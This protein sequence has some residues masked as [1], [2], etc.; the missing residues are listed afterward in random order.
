MF[1]SHTPVLPC[2]RALLFLLSL[3]PLLL[4][5]PAVVYSQWEPDRRLTFNAT[6]GTSPNNAWCVAAMGDSV[7]VVWFDRR[8]VDCEIYYKR[9]TDGGLTWGQDVQLSNDPDTSQSPSLAVAG[10]K[11]HVVWWDHRDGNREI[12]YKRSTDG[13]TTWGQEIRLTNDFSYSGSP[14]LAASGDSVHVVWQDY[15]D[16][17]LEVYYK[18]STDGGSSWLSE[19]R[20]TDNSSESACPSIAASGPKVHVVWYDYRDG[21]YEIYYKRSTDAG[22]TWGSDFRLSYDPAGSERPALAVSDSMIH[23]VWEDYRDGTNT[24]EIYYKRSTNG[25]TSWESDTRLTYNSDWS[26][27]PSMATSDPAVHIVWHDDRDRGSEIYYKRSTDRGMTWGSDTRLT[28]DSATSY[29]PSLAVSGPKVHVVW[30]DTRDGNNPPNCFEIY[31]KRNPTGNS[32]VEESSG[33]FY[34]LTSHLSFSVVPTPFT[35]FTAVFGHEGERFT[36]YDVS[37]RLVGKYKGDRVGEG[38]T[39]GV[40]FLRPEGK[41]AKPLRI[42]KLR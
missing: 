40:Y 3:A 1:F 14:S 13:G 7:H 29:R 15:R 11:V 39:A 8:N 26:D 34:P 2:S 41:D 16:G 21:N 9:S 22:G 36:L 10:P 6:S 28:F 32:G 5:A 19:S 27:Y 20:L 4:C 23:V 38:L 30:Y 12:Y 18:K 24:S 42:I 31:Y 25:G 33:S 35:S 37:G 17:N